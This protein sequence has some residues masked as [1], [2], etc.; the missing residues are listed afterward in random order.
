ML[1]PAEPPCVH[2]LRDSGRFTASLSP[3]LVVKHGMVEGGAAWKVPFGRYT[4]NKSNSNVLSGI[5]GETVG[6]LA[7]LPE[8]L[9]LVP[10][11]LLGRLT[12]NHPAPA[13]VDTI[14]T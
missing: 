4:H 3:Y 14:P 13:P 8:D 11:T 10:S 1:Y 7:A 5:T 12:H 6:V 9:G 2:S